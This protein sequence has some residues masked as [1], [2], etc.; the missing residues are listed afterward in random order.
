MGIFL[1]IY[2]GIYWFCN[3]RY[4]KYSLEGETRYNIAGFAT[5]YQ[6]YAYPANIRPRVSQV[7]CFNKK[8]RILIINVFLRTVRAM[9]AVKNSW[10]QCVRKVFF[11]G[12]PRKCGNFGDLLFNCSVAIMWLLNVLK[13]TFTIANFYNNHQK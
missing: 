3:F 9:L 13:L 11:N 7:S 2:I 8:T 12:K 10:K 1:A 6:Y 5:V 4:E